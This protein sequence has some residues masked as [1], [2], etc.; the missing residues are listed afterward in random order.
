MPDV[1]NRKEAARALKISVETL[2]RY[3]TA[4]KLPYH[5]IGDRVIFTPDDLT[6]FL[7]ACGVPATAEPTERE[8]KIMANV[9]RAV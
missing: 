5:R 3:R 6:K 4:G 9:S 8:S 1:Y 7:D 2:D